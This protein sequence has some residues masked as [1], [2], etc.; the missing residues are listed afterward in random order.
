MTHTSTT[1]TDI[2]ISLYR[3]WPWPR[4]EGI[5]REERATG[6]LT[7]PWKQKIVSP[8]QNDCVR[9]R[10]NFFISENQIISYLLLHKIQ[11]ISSFRG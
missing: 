3:V 11:L 7:V 9:A 6:K 4:N 2:F 10:Q 5:P 8:L 1:R